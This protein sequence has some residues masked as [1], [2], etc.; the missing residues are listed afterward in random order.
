[1]QAIIVIKRTRPCGK[2]AHLFPTPFMRNSLVLTIALLF[3]TLLTTP[4]LNG[5]KTVS[6]SVDSTL[7]NII[8]WLLVIISILFIYVLAL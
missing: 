6:L 7:L 2:Q 1:M 8:H 4:L 5:E 3:G